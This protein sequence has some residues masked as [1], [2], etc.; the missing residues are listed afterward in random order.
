MEKLFVYGDYFVRTIDDHYEDRKEMKGYGIFNTHT[1]VC[2]YSTTLYFHAIK[3]CRICQDNL[4][5]ALESKEKEIGLH[6][7]ESTDEPGKLN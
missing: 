6:W 1:G 3:W 7:P 4:V 2:E 5:S